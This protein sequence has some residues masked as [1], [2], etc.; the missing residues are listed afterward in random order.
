MQYNL[1]RYLNRTFDME[2]VWNSSPYVDLLG[3]RK[4]ETIQFM[5]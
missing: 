3:T 2:I 5:S 4:K 1:L